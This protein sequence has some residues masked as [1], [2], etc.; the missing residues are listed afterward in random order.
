MQQGNGVLRACS[1]VGTRSGGDLRRL[2]SFETNDLKPADIGARFGTGISAH[3]KI[4]GEMAYDFNQ[5][6]AQSI[7]SGSGETL[8]EESNLLPGEFGPKLE[9]GDDWV[10]PFLVAKVEFDKFFLDA[11][12]TAFSC[13]SSAIHSV[14]KY[15]D[16]GV[17]SGRGLEG[18]VDGTLAGYGR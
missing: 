12:P 5:A 3:V 13:L 17:L 10:R 6:T 14:P 11:R 7:T 9:A 18:R 2:F 4:E 1:G 15:G 8:L 16:P